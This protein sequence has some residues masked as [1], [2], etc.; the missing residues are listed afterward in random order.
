MWPWDYG[1]FLALAHR[2]EG[3]DVK[4]RGMG[5]HRDTSKAVG[6]TYIGDSTLESQ[7]GRIECLLKGCL[8]WI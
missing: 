5:L 2:V 8:A 7:Q 3:A 6:M 4:K 1:I